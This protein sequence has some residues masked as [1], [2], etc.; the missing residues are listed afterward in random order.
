MDFVAIVTL[1]RSLVADL[2]EILELL[3]LGSLGLRLF[4]RSH[5]VLQKLVAVFLTAS[6]TDPLRITVLTSGSNGGVQI[7]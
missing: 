5:E 3:L 2:K 6:G 7:A 4:N 1:P